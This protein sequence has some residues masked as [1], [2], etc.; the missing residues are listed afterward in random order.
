MN[1]NWKARFTNKAFLISVVSTIV[2]LSQ[3]LGLSIFP[4]NWADI[5]N[6]ILTIFILLG[7][8]IDPSTPGISDQKESIDKTIDQN[9]EG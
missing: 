6:T 8:V 9:R 7:I 3:Q 1:I 4:E 5:F 2:L